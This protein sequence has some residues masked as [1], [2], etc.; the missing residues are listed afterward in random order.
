MIAKDYMTKIIQTRAEYVIGEDCRQKLYKLEQRVMRDVTVY[1][2]IWDLYMCMNIYEIY[3]CIWVYEIY[4]C[5]CIM[6]G[7]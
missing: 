2:C 3:K 1:E 4:K 7:L 6:R 5:E